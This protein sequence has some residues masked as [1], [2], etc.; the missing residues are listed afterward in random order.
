MKDITSIGEIL[1][2]I[3][4]NEKY[5]GGAPFN[6]IYHIINIIGKGNFIGRIGNDEFGNEIQKFFNANN[7][8]NNFLQIDQKHKT[9]RA[10]ANLDENKIPHWLIEENCAYDFL[11]NKSE[12]VDLINEKTQCLYFGTLCQRS[13]VSRQTIQSLFNKNII[14]FC[15]L[16]IRQNYY[17]QDIILKSLKTSNVLKINDEELILINKLLFNDEIKEEKFLVK[18]LIK[19][20]FIDLICVTKGRNGAS[21][22][23]SN[24]ESH[25]KSQIDSVIDTVGAGDAF[26]AILCLGYLKKMDLH[27]LNKLCNNFASKI[28]TIEGALPKDK[29]FYNEMIKEFNNGK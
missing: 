20:Y 26:A 23:T 12:I 19:K 10:I 22:Y 7:I 17:S 2:D 11:E 24:D 18:H 3:N 16:N 27:K 6:F 25:Y 4:N 15:D 29:N 14:Y 9:G 13:D 28:C 1:F 21:I 5:L 8:S